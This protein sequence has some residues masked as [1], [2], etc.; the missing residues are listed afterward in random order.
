M[1]PKGKKEGETE[2]E[3]KRQFARRKTTTD[4]ARGPDISFFLNSSPTLP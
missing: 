1:R 4:D 3:K 2:E